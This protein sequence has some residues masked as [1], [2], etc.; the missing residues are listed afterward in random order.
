MRARVG[1]RILRCALA[2][3]LAL[4]AALPALPAAAC[5]PLALALRLRRRGRLRRLLGVPEAGVR[6]P[7]VGRL[8]GLRDVRLPAGRRDRLRLRDRGRRGPRG[9]VRRM[10]LSRLHGRAPEGLLV[11][12]RL[13]QRREPR[14]GH[15]CALGRRAVRSVLCHRRRRGHRV[16]L[17]QLLLHAL[18][19]DAGRDQGAGRQRRRLEREAAADRRAATA[20]EQ[21]GERARQRDRPERLERASV[22]ALAAGE[23]G[24]VVALAQV[25]AQGALLLAGQPPVELA[26]DRE[27]GLLARDRLLELL[28]QGAAR[29][30]EERLHRADADFEDLRDLLVA[31]ALELA[32]DDRGTLVEGEVAERP[33]DVLGRQRVLVDDA[34][35]ELLLEADLGR[36]PLRLAEA[37]AADVV[38][39]RDQPVLGLLRAL[40]ALEGAIGVEERRL[41]DVL[42]VRLVPEH[43][44]GVAVHVARVLAVEPLKRAIVAQTPREDWSHP[45]KD[46]GKRRILHPAFGLWE[47]RRRWERWNGHGDR[48]RWQ[49]REGRERRHGTGSGG[50]VGSAGVFTTTGGAGGATPAG[51]A[52][53]SGCAGAAVDA[54]EAV[55]R[56]SGPPAAV[57]PACRRRCV[58]ATWFAR[59]TALVDWPERAE[60]AWRRP[61]AG[62]R[63]PRR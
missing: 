48:G 17:L 12:L 32:H 11:V 47:R 35:G 22:R 13:L 9:R 21:A 1:G 58:V 39:D 56:A 8:E 43:D 25:C 15:R 3:A 7:H 41:G 29:A 49:R 46:A 45:L 36:A 42:G 34:L 52:D 19:P 5:V 24:A 18:V 6:L 33:P 51:G 38:R 31:A 20:A 14:R 30:E 44:E 62:R 57:R 54:V 37:L 59:C 2:L 16:G 26:R 60:P 55:G 10:R 63:R 50:T 27:L 61:A 23:A 28:A 40:A 53:A 4:A